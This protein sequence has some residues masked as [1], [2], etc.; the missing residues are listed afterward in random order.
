M[1]TEKK[2]DI[3]EIKMVFPCLEYLTTDLNTYMCIHAHVCV[4]VCKRNRSY[5]GRQIALRV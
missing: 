2:F 5:V 4:F 3:K 1:R